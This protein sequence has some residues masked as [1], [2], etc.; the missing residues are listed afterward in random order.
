MGRHLAGQA[1]DR[2][3]VH[4]RVGE[5]GHG[6]RG[7]RPRCDQHNPDLAGGTGVP[8][9]GVDRSLLVPH[10]NVA[11]V[12]LLENRIVNREYGPAWISEYDLYTLIGESLKDDFGAVQRGVGHRIASSI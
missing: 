6:I 4:Q 1:N 5:T 8:F 2:N 11:D 7:A 12:I 9:G 3:R 10:Q